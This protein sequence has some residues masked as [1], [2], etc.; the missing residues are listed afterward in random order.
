MKVNREGLL[1]ALLSLSPGLAS[2]EIIEQS[3]CIVF[4]EDGRA[5]SFNDEICASRRTPLNGIVGAIK[6]K[7]LLDL[8]TK[9]TEEDIDIE[10]VPGELLIKGKGKGR[11]SGLRMEANVLLPVSAVDVP[12]AS[13]WVELDPNFSEGVSIVHSCAGTEQTEFVTVCV[14][15]HPDWLEATDKL[16]IARYP[17]KTGV[18]RSTLVRAESIRK[19]LGY[20]MTMINETPSWIHFKNPSG[21]IISI[22]RDLSEYYELDQYLK[23]DGTV[24]VTLPGGLE[25]AVAKAEIF[26]SESSTGNLVSVD[27]KPGWILI[28]GTGPS[29]YYKERQ[30]V[31]Y[32]GQPFKFAIAPRLLVEISKKSSDC[33][34]SSTR[35]FIDG[36]KFLYAT[37]TKVRSS[38]PK[39][40]E[41]KAA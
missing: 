30:E 20:D 4:T 6:A 10:Q 24:P 27:L 3:S 25:E 33:R 16:Q 21:L 37:S 29:G 34:V 18:S 15:I 17:I 9:M 12:D 31:V 7:N 19:I 14:H 26:S 40:V 13:S 11:K 5:M 35:L 28:E 2:R 22:R 23:S 36:G 1:K 41:E 32:D 8:L 39:E 38:E